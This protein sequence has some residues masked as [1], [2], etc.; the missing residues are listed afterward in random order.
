MPDKSMDRVHC[1]IRWAP[2]SKLEK[3]FTKGSADRGKAMRIRDVTLSLLLLCS[4]VGCGTSGQVA[5]QVQPGRYAL[6][7]GDFPQAL[8]YF[9]SAAATDPN[10]VTNFTLLRQ[11]VWT[12]VGRTYYG[13]ANF[14]EA[15]KALERAISLHKDDYMAHLYLGLVRVRQ[16]DEAMGLREIMTGLTGLYDWLEYVDHN[17]SE[18]R[19]W[20]PGR[21]IR[22]QI[23]NDLAFMSGREFSWSEV[24]ARAEHVGDS[25]ETQIDQAKR[26]EERDR[27]EPGF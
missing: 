8:A 7:R 3:K 5:G 27:R 19:Y 18:G 1:P 24:V 21:V 23:Q 2:D 16:T 15:R 22:T 9:Q 17:L 10:Y 12:Y 25:I 6:R 20:D 26:Y 13:L 14:P 4:L 11:G